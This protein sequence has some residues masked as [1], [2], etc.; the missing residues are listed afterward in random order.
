LRGEKENKSSSRP[1]TAG[2][3]RSNSVVAYSNAGLAKNARNAK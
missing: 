2:I 3:T 1:T